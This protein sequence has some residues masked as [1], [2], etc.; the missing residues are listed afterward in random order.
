MQEDHQ[1]QAELLLHELKCKLEE[2]GVIAE[3][4]LQLVLRGSF[5]ITLIDHERL[6]QCQ[7]LLKKRTQEA[8]SVI[9]QLQQY[10]SA[11]DKLCTMHCETVANMVAAGVEAH[12]TTK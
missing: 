4:E 12:S 7:P 1:R 11:Q 10:F 9:N 3:E 8:T 5:R 2:L 6:E